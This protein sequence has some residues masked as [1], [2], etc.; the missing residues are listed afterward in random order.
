[1]KS[2]RTDITAEYLR[3]MLDFDRETGFFSWKSGVNRRLAAG[4]KAGTAH[5]S[6]YISIQV[7]GRAYLA[8]RLAWLHVFGVWPKE[9][10]DHINGERSDNRLVNLREATRIEN[11]RNRGAPSHNTSGFKGVYVTPKGR[12]QAHIKVGGK[13][14]FL[15]SFDLAEEA[16]AVYEAAASHHFGEF[17]RAILMGET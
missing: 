3:G 4:T 15:G 2:M 16:H 7:G 12:A 6:G 14:L 1:M 8:H 13:Q 10:L 17:H 5:G 9:F 11:S